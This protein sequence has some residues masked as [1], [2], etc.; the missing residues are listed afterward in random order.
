M[1]IYYFHLDD[2]SFKAASTGESFPDD[3]AAKAH[4]QAVA[5]DLAHNSSKEVRITVTD[6]HNN[7][8]FEVSGTG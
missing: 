4:A 6:Q 8:L 1:P 3:D 2:G 5:A 7:K